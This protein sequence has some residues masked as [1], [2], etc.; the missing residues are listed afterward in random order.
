M[1]LKYYF[2]LLLLPFFILFCSFTVH[3]EALPVISNDTYEVING[4]TDNLTDLYSTI[5]GIYSISDQSSN[6]GITSAIEDFLGISPRLKPTD[7]HIR[8][9]SVIEEE[10]LRDGYYEHFYDSQGNEIDISNIYYVTGNNGFY[11]VEFYIDQSGN[12]LVDDPNHTNVLL[13]VAMNPL[14]P[15]PGI[16]GSSYSNWDDVIQHLSNEIKLNNYNFSPD[17]SDLSDNGY[18]VWA[19]YSATY[20]TAAAYMLI[21]NQYNPG[22]IV[23]SD[24]RPGN[25]INGWFTNDLG[26]FTFKDTY[27][28]S[29]F[30]KV[31]SGDYSKDGHHYSY[32]VVFAEAYNFTGATPVDYNQ[33]LVDHRGNVFG[34]S[35]S[36]YNSSLYSESMRFAKIQ[37]SE[38]PI[39]N[40]NEMYDYNELELI[41]PL[42]NPDSN[43][44]YDPL[45]ELSPDNW[46][47]VFPA[48]GGIIDPS[49]LPL[50]G[51]NPQLNPNPA[52][53]DEPLLELDPTDPLGS[54]NIPFLSNLQNRYP[55]C[56]PWD[57]YRFINAVNVSPQAP[58]WDFDYAITVWGH[59]YIVHFQGDLSDFNPLAEIFRELTLL[60]FVIFV[61][62]WSYRHHF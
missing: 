52:P 59:T 31:T 11:D 56:I 51:S 62:L 48:P 49:T 22:I 18:F 30:L 12:L 61:S 57:I 27:G 29:G 55:F 44:D 16:T 6:G 7:Y 8:P 4:G 19:G 50:P 60:T 46:P 34:L 40:P 5:Y 9:L 43:P 32:H 42:T 2:I 37:T 17:G 41:N 35:G 24:I 10:N 45:H 53:G 47:N 3:A 25:Y 36:T 20:G 14:T 54:L 13:N 39:I 28:T 58:A 38:M 1:K 33:W 23:P 26:S 15:I 21:P